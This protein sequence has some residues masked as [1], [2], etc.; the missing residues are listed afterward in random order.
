MTANRTRV[1]CASLFL[2]AWATIAYSQHESI[3]MS[4]P[5]SRAAME[6]LRACPDPPF[7][8]KFL[9][10]SQWSLV[11]KSK[12]PEAESMLQAVSWVPLTNAQAGKL[13]NVT[14]RSGTTTP[15]LL[16]A[17]GS[18]VGSFGF[19]VGLRPNGE[20]LVEGAAL[21][22]RPVPVDRRAIIVWLHHPPRELYVYF[23][24]AE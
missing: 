9:D 21:A 3:D 1:Y 20:V 24:S 13:A 17:V 23:S 4:A 12:H 11:P 19:G 2:G 18:P 6:W 7:G 10:R 5:S 16:R 8:G 14:L 15:Y 22:R